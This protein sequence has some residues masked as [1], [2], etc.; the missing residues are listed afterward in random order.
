MRIM[1]RAWLP[2][3][4]GCCALLVA[5]S[6]SAQPRPQQQ[7][8]DLNRQAMEA[9]NNLEIDQARTLL[10]QA[11]QL[12]TQNHVT[13]A[14]LARTYLNLGVLQIGGLS[15]NAAG[16]QMFIQALR[17]D[18]SVQLDPLT[19]TPEIQL[20]YARARNEVGSTPVQTA[21]P[22]PSTEPPP[23]NIPHD[24]V[25]EQLAQTPVPVFLEVPPRQRVS[26][27]NLFYRGHGMRAYRQVAM[28]RMRGGYG[29][30][31]PCADVFEPAIYYYIEVIGRSGDRV[32][33]VGNEERP[34]TVP[35]VTTRNH[36]PP[37]LPGQ[38]PPQQCAEECPPGMPGC[39]GTGSGAGLGD[40]CTRTSDCADD[41]DCES[42]LCV[43]PEA[44]EEPQL[45]DEGEAPRIFLH[46]GAT[47]GSGY[48]SGGMLA[49]ATPP[50]E[51]PNQSAWVP[52][53]TGDCM[54]DA[55]LYC[56]RVATPGFVPAF[57][58][59]IAAGYYVLPRLALAL[60]A[61]IAFSSGVGSLANMVLGARAQY[62]LVEPKSTG[63][64]F[65]AFVGGGYGQIQISPSGNGDPAPWIISGLGSVSGGGVIGYRIVRNFG[66][67]ASVEA[68]FMVPTFLFNIDT[69]LGVALTF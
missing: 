16:L 61:R 17:A 31:I 66:I 24:S 56:V 34:V 64:T 55:E 57:A 7:V 6:A 49:D 23:S 39:G 33:F 14:P 18:G 50:P 48:A 21:D 53:Q 45:E 15:D 63:L 5:A 60:T 27:V 42:G 12:A 8:I 26:E 67:Q 65:D 43:N 62:A 38:A 44:S 9:Y 54:A 46:L 10:E 30:E 22:V 20:M 47:L 68:V 51:L 36:P 19:S 41:L 37:S 1:N 28:E 3:L 32:A 13:G 40:A 59:R 29:F 11:E 25:P 2:L 58:M 4:V 69:T 35:I 52:G